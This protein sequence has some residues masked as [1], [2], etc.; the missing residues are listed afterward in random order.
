LSKF[1]EA[2]VEDNVSVAESVRL[3]TLTPLSGIEAAGPGR[4][5]MLAAGSGSLD[6]L[7]KRPFSVFRYEK[8]SLQFLYRIRGKGTSCIARYR[9]G[10]IVPLLG[11]LGNTWPEPAGDFIVVAGGI[12][13]AS[14]YSLIEANPG[15][16]F[17]FC[18]YRNCD[19]LLLI[20]DI[21]RLSKRVSVTTDDGSY[22]RYGLIT[23]PFEE[24]LGS[25]EYLA[26]PLP[27][28]ACGPT[29]MMKKLAAIAKARGIACYVSLEEVM[30]CGV[31]ACLGCVCKT[32]AGYTRICKEGPVFNAEDVIW[33]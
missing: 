2:R 8:G 11:P 14:V 25:P 13:I 16:A 3:I 1:F 5:F 26:S 19:E 29:P 28:Y 31:G 4:F 21:Q 10:D 7:L 30:A 18:G 22:C 6:P 20:D 27:V 23:E 9:K 12:G 33:E 15:R 17:V 32:G 24:F